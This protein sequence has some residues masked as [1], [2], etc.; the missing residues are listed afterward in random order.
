LPASGAGAGGSKRAVGRAE[1]F[2]PITRPYFLAPPTH[3]KAPFRGRS[4][5]QSGVS[6]AAGDHAADW[7]RGQ[8]EM[9]LTA[10]ASGGEPWMGLPRPVSTV[11]PVGLRARPLSLGVS[12]IICRHQRSGGTMSSNPLS[13]SGESANHRYRSA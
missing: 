6:S 7:R 10:T 4:R 13:S 9:G 8:A 3:E 1:L 2:A 5:L 11:F 12:R